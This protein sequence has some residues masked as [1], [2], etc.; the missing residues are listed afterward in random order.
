MPN[1]D[2]NRPPSVTAPLSKCAQL[3]S[4]TSWSF[5][6]Y[7]HSYPSSCSRTL[8]IPPHQCSTPATFCWAS[9]PKS[10]CSPLKTSMRSRCLPKGMRTSASNLILPTAL[11]LYST[12][13]K[14]ACNG[15]V[16]MSTGLWR[17]CSSNRLLLKMLFDST[18]LP[19]AVW[20]SRILMTW[21][22]TVWLGIDSYHWSHYFWRGF[23]VWD[24]SFSWQAFLSQPAHSNFEFVYFS[25]GHP[26]KYVCTFIYC[27]F[28]LWKLCKNWLFTTGHLLLYFFL[29]LLSCPSLS[30]LF[31]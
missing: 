29:P 15:S 5:Q 13:Q 30:W 9:S 16:E 2:V 23:S 27:G 10:L 17:S 3:S 12:L 18:S 26:L 22:W 21:I 7:P 28:L 11:T 14:M 4:S 1:P 31:P 25:C 19:Y 6:A 24:W 8:W 20:F